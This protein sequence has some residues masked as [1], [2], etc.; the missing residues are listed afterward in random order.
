MAWTVAKED[1]K[2]NAI[3]VLEG[4]FY[5][6]D[7]DVLYNSNYHVIKYLD[8]YGDTTFNSLMFDDL[9]ND[10]KDLKQKISINTDQIDKI[11]KLVINSKS[12]VHIF[13]KFYGD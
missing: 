13:I 7:V 4:E 11:I 5:L 3:E 12:E 8:P 6:T 9:I 1:F 2:G 10:L